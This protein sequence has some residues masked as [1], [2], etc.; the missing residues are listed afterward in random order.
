MNKSSLRTNWLVRK[1]VVFSW[2]KFVIPD[3]FPFGNKSLFL[4]QVHLFLINSSY[5]RIILLF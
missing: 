3:Q 1:Q 5:F 4:E 2:N